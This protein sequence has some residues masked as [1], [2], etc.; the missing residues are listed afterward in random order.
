M[1]SAELV[2]KIETCVTEPRGYPA[3]SLGPGTKGSVEPLAEPS[4]S[5]A[6]VAATEGG[7]HA[8]LMPKLRSRPAA[9]R[10]LKAAL[11]EQ[12]RIARKLG[13]KAVCITLTYRAGETYTSKDLSKFRAA[14]FAQVRRSHPSLKIPLPYLW[15]LDRSN[16]GAVKEPAASANNKGLLWPRLLAATGVG[17]P[18]P[19]A[20][21]R[22]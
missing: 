10:K 4:D 21:H 15:V 2:N 11:G 19:N 13:L 6:P 18:M 22:C 3:S 16:V 7:H 12:R 20:A 9:R 1:G 17:N 14:L 8:Q 5:P